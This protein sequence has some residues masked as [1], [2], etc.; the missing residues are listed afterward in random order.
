M[1]LSVS[2]R[3]CLSA[4]VGVLGL[5]LVADA[6][7]RF[8]DAWQNSSN[9]E[10]V[11]KTALA[12]RTIL[13]ARQALR[14]ER[15]NS[16]GYLLMS[17]ADAARVQG[18]LKQTRGEVDAAITRLKEQGGAAFDAT[19][20]DKLSVALQDYEAL[21]ALR[22][23][24]DRA[25]LQEPEKRDAAFSGV[26]TLQAD[27]SLAGLERLSDDL[28]ERMKRLAPDT[29]AFIDIKQA[30][31]NTRAAVG[32]GF[33]VL[34][35]AMVKRTPVAPA[36]AETMA[37]A[38]GKS[39]ASWKLVRAGLLH[40]ASPGLLTQS[41]DAA[42]KAVFAPEARASRQAIRDSLAAGGDGGIPVAEFQK[43]NAE[44]QRAVLTV[45]TVAMDQI[46]AQSEALAAEA[47]FEMLVMGCAIAAVLALTLGGL[48][49]MQL[50]VIR[51]LGA[52]TAAMRSLSQGMLA[53]AVP[54]VGR[55]D[56]IGSMAEAVQVFKDNLIHTRKLEAETAQAR[57][58]AEEQRK[59]GMRQM[60]DGFEAAVGGI[61]SMVSSSATELQATAQ[62]M[63]AT[64]TETASQ[65]TT[66]AS[67]A[68]AAAINVNTVAAAAEELGAS[69]VEISRQVDSSADL[70]RRAVIEADQTGSLVQELSTT[71]AR[72]GD[73]VA[74]ITSIAGQTNL[75][76]LNA[77]I[78]AAR[79]GE[80]GRGFAVVA[81]EVKE[82]ANQTAQATSEISGQ[83]SRIQASTGQAVSAIGGITERIREISN[84]ATSIAAAVEEQG[85]ATQEIVRNIGQAAQGTGEVTSNIAGVAGAAEE[86]GAAASQVLGAASELSRQSEHLSSEV[87]HFLDT[88][89]AA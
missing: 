8:R 17:V 48:V 32:P 81:S 50:R 69:V 15:S 70:A 89:R 21:S 71:V 2:I 82:L 1:Q 42:E 3:A 13:E 83:I 53:V 49:L 59:A 36:A 55:R 18:A 47:R 7:W 76:A 12:D 84:V 51:P 10:V 5:L 86:T 57:L 29:R 9:V 22:P 78:E 64:A 37:D 4:I 45:A 24:L 43:D 20:Q 56:E 61:I 34:S 85:A 72:I 11:R 46:V 65:S 87:S 68:E 73:V 40:T 66:V 44:R 39:E 63:T 33:A 28:G 14:F 79:A 23:L 6:G 88:V 31:W 16:I 54:G 58:A 30:A 80:A 67:A 27:R 60:A 41:V 38:F 35:Q 77:T 62:T 19:L 25:L 74:M 52:M 26:W 75:L